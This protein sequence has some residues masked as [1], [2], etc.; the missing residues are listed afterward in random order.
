[1]VGHP[2]A[3]GLHPPRYRHGGAATLPGG[4]CLASVSSPGGEGGW[5]TAVVL[6]L[7]PHHNHRAR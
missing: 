1:M 3:R 4:A 2:Q 5:G 7:A 6:T